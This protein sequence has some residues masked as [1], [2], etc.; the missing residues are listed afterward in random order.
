METNPKY[1]GKNSVVKMF[2]LFPIK[3]HDDGDS[4]DGYYYHC[5]GDDDD[6]DDDNDD[7]NL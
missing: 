3:R 2:T 1:R 7:S 6:D 4:D 5:V